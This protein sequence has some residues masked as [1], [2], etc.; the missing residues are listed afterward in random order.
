MLI[1]I[2]KPITKAK[3]EKVRRALLSKKKKGFNPDP[4]I[5]KIKWGG[6]A[7]SIQREMRDEW[8]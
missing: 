1:E 2:T 7:L 5:G 3:L 6:D 8:R 4:F